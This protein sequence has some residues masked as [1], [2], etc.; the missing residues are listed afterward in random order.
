[1]KRYQRRYDENVAQVL[2]QCA[3]KA[4]DIL[5]DDGRS[6]VYSGLSR[7]NWRATANTPS[8]EF[9]PGLEWQ[10]ALGKA[11]LLALAKA[12]TAGVTHST[13]DVYVTNNTSYIET[14]GLKNTQHIKSAPKQWYRNLIRQ[15]E[16]EI[17]MRARLLQANGVQIHRSKGF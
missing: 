1:M 10:S 11:Q 15:L 17:K 8:S 7:S 5:S 2:K 16:H 3:L 9:N 4:V 6:P 12:G 14:I 13:K